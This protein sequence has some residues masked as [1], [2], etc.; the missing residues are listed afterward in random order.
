[1]EADFH[2]L[3]MFSWHF[4]MLKRFNVIIRPTICM[5][6]SPGII[7]WPIQIENDY[8]RRVGYFKTNRH[9][10]VCTLYTCAHNYPTA[11]AI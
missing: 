11:G 3:L 7:M 1:M 10:V 2:T 6:M 4:Q 9:P 5:Y 8:I